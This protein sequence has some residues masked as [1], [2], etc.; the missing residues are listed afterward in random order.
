M[1]GTRAK[2]FLRQE[3]LECGETARQ[4]SASRHES[5]AIHQKAEPIV[6]SGGCTTIQLRCLVKEKAQVSVR[7]NFL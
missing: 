3:A 2:F 4:Q 1:A 6:T 5:Y 7:R